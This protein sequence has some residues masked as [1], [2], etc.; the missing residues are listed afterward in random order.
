MTDNPTKL[1]TYEISRPHGR[2]WIQSTSRFSSADEASVALTGYLALTPEDTG[3]FIGRVILAK[4]IP[5]H[6]RGYIVL[7]DHSFEA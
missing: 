5:P 6:P 3:S 4:E 7:H 1:W 2:I